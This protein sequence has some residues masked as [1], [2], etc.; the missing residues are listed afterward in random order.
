MSLTKHTQKKFKVGQEVRVVK[1]VKQEDGWDNM[2]LTGV[3]DIFISDSRF[4]T[5]V[6]I[7]KDG[8]YFGNE[9]TAYGFPEGS[10]EAK[11][12]VFPRLDIEE[13]YR[14]LD[15]EFPTRAEAEKHRAA[16]EVRQLFAGMN[17]ADRPG[18]KIIDE[19]INSKEK[20]IKLLQEL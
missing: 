1:R 3:M 14:V 9:P 12:I 20:F 7:S 11:P 19:I 8:Y 10:L 2:W 16:L 15:V 13:V 4:H 6:K 18:F 5:I 17:F